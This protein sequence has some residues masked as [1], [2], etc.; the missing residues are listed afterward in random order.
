MQTSLEKI[1]GE[2]TLLSMKEVFATNKQQSGSDWEHQL[3]LKY[4]HWWPDENQVCR[5]KP[6]G[7]IS[8]WS[9]RQDLHILNEGQNI[10]EE[11]RGILTIPGQS[12]EPVWVHLNFVTQY[13]NLLEAAILFGPIVRGSHHH[14]QPKSLIPGRMDPWLLF[15]PNL[16]PVFRMS[17]HKCTH[18]TRQCLSVCDPVWSSAAAAHICNEGLFELLGY[19]YDFLFQQVVLFCFV[20]CWENCH[21]LDV[22]MLHSKSVKSPLPPPILVLSLNLSRSPWSRL[23][24]C[25]HSLFN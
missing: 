7:S 24:S 10:S 18:Q 1:W 19:S 13:A 5:L 15:V 23:L 6:G 22:F 25:C 20:F 4:C 21:S 14:H 2:C 16:D 11:N 17:Q 8:R 3:V 9:L 12:Q